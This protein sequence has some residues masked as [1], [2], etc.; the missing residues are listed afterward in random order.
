MATRIGILVMAAVIACPQAAKAER[1]DNELNKRM[2]DV[3]EH[4]KKKYANVGVLRF[5]VQ[6][7]SATESFTSPMAGRMTERLETLLILHN[8]TDEEKHLGVIHNAG[9]MAARRGVANWYTSAADRKKLFEQK[10]LLAWG[11]RGVDPDA[12]LTGKLT[13]SK[14]R[15]KT[16]VEL[17]CFDKDAPQKLQSLGTFTIDTDRFVL[18]DMGYSFALGQKSKDRLTVARSS[19]KEED[20]LIVEE[21]NQSREGAGAPVEP[22]NVGGVA[23]EL[24]NSGS[25]VSIRQASTA[26][27]AIKWQMESPPPGG[28][29]TVRLRNTTDKRLAVV[30]RFNGVNTINEQKLE[31][32]VAAKWVLEP[33][34]SYGL[35]GFYLLQPATVATARKSD[36]ETTPTGSNKGTKLKDFRVVVGEEAKAMAAELGEK[37]GLIEIDVFEEGA[38]KEEELLISMKGLPP[39]KD[40]KAREACLGL[41]DALLKS[42]NLKTVLVK[43][44]DGDEKSTKKELI[45]PDKEAMATD[46]SI[47]I[48]GFPHAR[49]A[50]RA[51]IKVVAAD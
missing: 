27:D 6:D 40:K 19:F 18:R 31:P 51:T 15:K 47:K 8:G 21:V 34:R 22:S 23:F 16:T 37:K 7:G 41:R 45:V 3:V 28:Q 17:E 13:L 43:R 49:L 48:T 20:S 33:Q 11:S 30:L 5:R 44:E 36:E 35:K 2:P 9:G 10:Y 14:D 24:L 29:V 12:F 1:L 32:E 25:P 46:E 4:L 26:G 42:N 39:G 38:P 50:A